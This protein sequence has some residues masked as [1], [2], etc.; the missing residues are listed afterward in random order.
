MK[1]IL[2]LL[3]C[4]SLMLCAC[5]NNSVS[6]EEHEKLRKELEEL[7]E[8]LNQSQTGTANDP[9][10]VS[11]I[12]KWEGRTID[13]IVTLELNADDSYTLTQQINGESD[14][15]SGTY[16]ITETTITLQF[17]DEKSGL[18][19]Y[20]KLEYETKDKTILINFGNNQKISFER[21]STQ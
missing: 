8:S 1:K 12:G 16:T 14:S 6:Q 2:L 4:L 21:E 7:R 13:T 3:L 20:S 11:K 15:M 19:A 10:K 17:V 5:G 18:D 9:V